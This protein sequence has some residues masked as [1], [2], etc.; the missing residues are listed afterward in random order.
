[1]KKALEVQQH[2]EGSKKGERILRT[3]HQKYSTK[4]SETQ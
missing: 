4:R 1:M 2:R 3:A